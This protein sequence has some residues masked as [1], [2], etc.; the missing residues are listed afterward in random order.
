MTA[1]ALWALALFS[2]VMSVTPGPNNMMLLASGLNFGFA[3][4]VPHMLGIAA[5]AGVML[6]VLALGLGALLVRWPL[7]DA[8]LQTVSALWLIHLA[9]RLGTAT[10]PLAALAQPDGPPLESPAAQ[11]AKT[12]KTA[13]PMTALGAAAFQWANPKAWMMV[14]TLVASYL[15]AAPGGALLAMVV[16]VFMAINLCSVSVWAW[17]GRALRRWLAHPVRLRWFNRV[18]AL[19]LLASLWPVV[20]G[21]LQHVRA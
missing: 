5:G 13:R 2:F 4:T 1:S 16:L 12:A 15:P 10:T 14:T 19:T 3:R 21:A 17:A 7:L 11:S 6:V 18:M 20:S 8:L 9:W